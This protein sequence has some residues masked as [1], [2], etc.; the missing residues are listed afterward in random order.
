[1]RNNSLDE[2]C[3]L[4]LCSTDELCCRCGLHMRFVIVEQFYAKHKI[5]V[6]EFFYI[7]YMYSHNF[8]CYYVFRITVL[9]QWRCEKW[10]KHSFEFSCL[11]AM[12]YIGLDIIDGCA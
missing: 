11:T 7:R 6:Y 2:S 3:V 12:S 10:K 1:M 4:V 8:V 5:H 9:S